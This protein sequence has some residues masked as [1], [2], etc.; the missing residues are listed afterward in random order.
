MTRMVKHE[1]LAASLFLSVIG[2]LIW[3]GRAIYHAL[4]HY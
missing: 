2:L 1:M 3:A 4:H